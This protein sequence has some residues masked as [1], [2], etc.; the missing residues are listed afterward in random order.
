MHKI[1]VISDTHN[2]LRPEVLSALEGC[3]VILHAGDISTPEIYDRLQ[4]IRTIYAVRGNN[5]RNWASEIPLVLQFELYGIQICMTHIK[6]NIPKDHNADLVIYGHSHRY[7][8]SRE[9]D[10]VYLNP[11]SCGPRRFNQ[12]ITMAVLKLFEPDET[13]G[14]DDFYITGSGRKIVVERIDIPH[15]TPA[16]N[17]A[18][19]RKRKT[20]S[21]QKQNNLPG[22][23]QDA[24]AASLS[25]RNV[26]D[27]KKTVTTGL[28]RMVCYDVDHERT[29]DEIAERRHIDPE[30]TEQIVRM[31]LTHQK[32]TPEQIMAK[33]G[34]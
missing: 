13:G 12:E 15:E 26:P 3:E 30:L 33:L 24:S 1:A 2:L 28:I 11:G 21:T 6:R 10:T 18:E 32:V 23:A 16:G 19:Q 27:Y 34:L 22:T 7:S 9:R 4:N 20:N 5:D 25:R 31:Y 8:C 14:S 29:V 17:T